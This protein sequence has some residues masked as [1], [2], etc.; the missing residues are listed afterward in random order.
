MYYCRITALGKGLGD[1]Q[2]KCLYFGTEGIEKPRHRVS[3]FFSI[4]FKI[5]IIHEKSLRQ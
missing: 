5:F 1:K 3:M 2:N 4:I